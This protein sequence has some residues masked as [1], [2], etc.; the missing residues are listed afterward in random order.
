ML[1]KDFIANLLYGLVKEKNKT[2]NYKEMFKVDN[3]EMHDVWNLPAV[4]M[5]EKNFFH[6][7]QDKF[8]TIETNDKKERIIGL[9]IRGLCKK[10][11]NSA[12]EFYNKNSNL[13]SDKD[14]VRIENYDKMIDDYIENI[15]IKREEQYYKKNRKYEEL[16][17]CQK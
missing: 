10:I 16:I 12:K 1:I 6:T 7:H 11:I 2:F 14:N 5:N 4:Q 17:K 13:F 8:D 15:Y 9:N 3:E